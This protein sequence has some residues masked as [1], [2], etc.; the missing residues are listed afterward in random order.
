MFASPAVGAMA[1]VV[2]V[3]DGRTIEVDRAGARERVT[4]AGVAITDALRAQELLR[5]TI[6]TSWVMLESTPDGALVYRSPDALFINRELVLRGY[7]KAT[8]PGIEPE[9]RLSVTYLG[10][11]DRP[12]IS[13][14]RKRTR[15]DTRRPPPAP[16]SRAARAGRGSPSGR[17]SAASSAR[18]SGSRR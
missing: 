3:V 8:L 2:A 13:A 18:S 16:R 1:R 10:E 17:R 11:L 4:L 12:G 7:A 6:G 15:S 9:Q 14:D 5:W